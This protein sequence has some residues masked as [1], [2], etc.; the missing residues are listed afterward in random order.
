MSTKIFF[1]VLTIVIGLNLASCASTI[2][3][4][5]TSTNALNHTNWV[6][7]KLNNQS[8]I[9]NALIT[10]NFEDGNI[11]GTDGC[12]RYHTAYTQNA[13]T[14]SINKN[15]A[16]TMMACPEPI[17]QQAANYMTALTETA[18]Y[19]IDGQQLTL[20]NASGKTLAS[21]TKQS[22][23]LGGTAWRVTS[24]NNGKQA[25]VS[26]II[27][28]NL[29][30]NFSTDGKLSGS[31]GCNNYTAN[32]KVSGKNIKIGQVAST[33]KMCAKP[34][35]VMEQEAQFLH[36]LTTASTYQFDG[37]RLELRTAD[38][39]LAVMLVTAH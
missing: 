2:T 4:A 25:V 38:N 36:A 19:K 3:S 33:R 11:A 1:G 31:A 10:L 26:T 16:S 20:L 7:A 32:Y 18:H 5:D 34:D 29:T 35:G 9:P 37:N 17:T 23:E 27:D 28:S 22:M 14:L 30:A 15:S 24:S 13:D 8:V 39:A 12:N 21:F 6:L